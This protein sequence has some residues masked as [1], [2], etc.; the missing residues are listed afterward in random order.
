MKRWLFKRAKTQSPVTGGALLDQLYRAHYSDL[1]KN[2]NVN[3]G[4]GPPEPEDVVQAAFIKFA[5]LDD[6]QSI[7]NPRSFLFVAA[8]NLVLDYKRRA[9]LNDAYLADQIALDA[10]LLLEEITPERVVIA[11]DYFDRL[12]AA[13][14][15]LPEK[16][17][18]VLAM[19][20]LEGKS[21]QQIRAETGWSPADISRT[22]RA[23]ME[24]VMVIMESDPR[25]SDSK[26]AP[27]DENDKN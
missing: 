13:I 24:T 6:P 9:K 22:L 20:R 21:Y 27:K 16:Q 12:S 14:R 10:E 8:R 4:P 17:Q 19:S 18:I 23:G 5:A 15:R 1:C 11:K 7:R 25:L 2:I 26:H 3:F